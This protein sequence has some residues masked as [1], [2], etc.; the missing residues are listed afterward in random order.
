MNIDK[1]VVIVSS[2]ILN[3]LNQVLLVQRSQKSSYPDYWQLV[4]GKLEKGE[5]LEV[6]LKREIREE[7]GL[8]T[9]ELIL[10][11]VFYNELE[12]KGSNYLCIRVVFNTNAISTQISI[13]DEHAAFGWFGVEEALALSLLPGTK[14]ILDT[15][16]V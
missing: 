6:A 14:A 10:N 2:I 8:S 15:L 3:P 12:A 7:T 13:S 11:N 16:L 4:E 9:S 1:V 5:S